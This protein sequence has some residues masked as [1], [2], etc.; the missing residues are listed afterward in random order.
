MLLLAETHSIHDYV[1]VMRA[2][3]TAEPAFGETD[4]PISRCITLNQIK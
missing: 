3:T 2:I 4:S 1:N